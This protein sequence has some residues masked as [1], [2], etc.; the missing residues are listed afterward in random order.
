MIG[1]L[2]D[3]PEFKN[4]YDVEERVIINKRPKKKKIIYREESESDSEE[5]VIIKRKP[6]KHIEFPA[7][8]YQEPLPAPPKFSIKFC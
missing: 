6:R 7:E 3:I 5:E 8:T 1:D 4:D 2:E